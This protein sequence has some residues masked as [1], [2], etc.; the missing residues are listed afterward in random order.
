MFDPGNKIA[1][2]VAT[3]IWDRDHGHDHDRGMAMGNRTLGRTRV[4]PN[5]LS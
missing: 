4:G 2:K 3:N 1:I 5:V